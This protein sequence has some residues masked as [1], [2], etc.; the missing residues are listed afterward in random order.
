MFS[1]SALTLTLFACTPGGSKVLQDS[2]AKE[3]IEVPSKTSL[4][5]EW[6]NEYQEKN[7]QWYKT[8]KNRRAFVKEFEKNIVSNIDF[9]RSVCD[10][11]R[12]NIVNKEYI[13]G[14]DKGDKLYAFDLGE[15][16]NVVKEQYKNCVTFC[17]GS[18]YVYGTVIEMLKGNKND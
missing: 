14:N 8:D 5:Q 18:F 1:A 12:S 9:A 3:P 7:P 13:S 6:L 2:I 17:V 11:N 4:Y 16:I 10:D 15:A